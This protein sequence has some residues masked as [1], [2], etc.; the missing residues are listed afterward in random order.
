MSDF[1]FNTEGKS[2]VERWGSLIEGKGGLGGATALALAS[3]RPSHLVLLA[4]TEN[5]VRTVISTIKEISPETQPAFV[6]IEL[7]DLD[8]VRR[9]AADVLSLTSKID[10]LI[11]NAGVMAIPWSKS[12]SGLE[13]TLAINHIGHFLLTKL[14]MPSILAAGPGSR[15]V[16]VTS[17]AYRMAPFFFDD[18]NFSVRQADPGIDIP[19][20]SL[21]LHGPDLDPSAMDE[22]A[23]KNTG[24]P[25]GP[26][27]P[28]SLEQGISTTLVAA[29]SPEL[30]DA[31]GAYMEDCQVCEAREYARD[32]KLADRLW[33][34]SEEL[35][36]EAF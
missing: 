9:A 25:F 32:P 18:W 7:E 13:K 30:T 8:S 33:S 34:L 1:D 3:A 19:G 12:K 24:F 17:A 36:S 4:R 28:K 35:A 29:L 21:L 14:L 5:K 11:N 6:H 16:N 22:V 20:T 26:D 23:R 31:S 2:V 27:P 15:I 10:V